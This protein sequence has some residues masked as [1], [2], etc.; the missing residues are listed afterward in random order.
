MIVSGTL[1]GL[2][3]S[4]G[5]AEKNGTVSDANLTTYHR[6]PA[7]WCCHT[8][9]MGRKVERPKSIGHFLLGDEIWVACAEKEYL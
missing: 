7:W 5:R 4:S 3:A 8:R 6:L 2:G 1:G 9:F